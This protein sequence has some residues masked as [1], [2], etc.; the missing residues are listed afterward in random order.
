[1]IVLEI[2]ST[3]I[4]VYQTPDVSRIFSPILSRSTS[5]LVSEEKDNH[6]PNAL[7]PP[8]VYHPVCYYYLPMLIL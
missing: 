8:T 2:C 7:T 6:P 5:L 3:A 4:Q 1:M